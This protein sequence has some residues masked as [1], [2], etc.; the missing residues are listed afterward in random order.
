VHWSRAVAHILRQRGSGNPLM[1]RFLLRRFALALVTLVLLSMIVFAAAQLLPGNVGRNVLGGF[2][3]QRSVDLFNHQHGVDRPVYIQYIH[4]IGHLLHGDLGSSL[5]YSVSVW[6]LIG[7]SLVNSL[8]LAALAFVLVVPLSIIGG[9]AAALRQ[10]RLTDRSITVGGLS[11]TA[12][13]EFVTA[14]VLIV[15]FGVALPWLPTTAQAPPGASFFVQ[16]KFLLLPSLALVAVL[17]GYIARIARAG[18]IEA[19]DADYTRT[20]YLKGLDTRAVM[21]RH[22]LRNALL[23]TI[24]V[25]ATQT[26]YLIGGLVVIEKVFNYPG[27]GQRIYTAAV[28]KDFTMLESGVL[29]VGVVYLVATLVAD[30]LYSLLNPRIRYGAA[31]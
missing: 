16:I 7:P 24:A 26:G 23:P 2:A 3:D 25:V 31:E 6:S 12:V 21:F 13:P 28:N 10:G 5:E 15:I 27:I 9:V 19:L 4:W 1:G 30:T 29:I 8:K 22:V 20:A 17:F 11:L 18:V 14:I